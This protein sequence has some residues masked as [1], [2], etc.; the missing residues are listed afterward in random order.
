MRRLCN[1]LLENYPDHVETNTDGSNDVQ[2]FRLPKLPLPQDVWD[3]YLRTIMYYRDNEDVL[4][5]RKPSSP[6]GFWSAVADMYGKRRDEF[7]GGMPDDMRKNFKDLMKG[8][9]N[10]RAIDEEQMGS[11]RSGKDALTTRAV[12]WIQGAAVNPLY[13]N[14]SQQRYAALMGCA[15]LLLGIR[16]TLLLWA[17]LRWEGDCILFSMKRDKES[18]DGAT[19]KLA[20]RSLHSHPSSIPEVDFFLW[21]GLR[22]GLRRITPHIAFYCK[23]TDLSVLCYY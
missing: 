6:N 21:L 20:V 15:A 7:P 11:T 4:R 9:G 10:A 22:K 14:R 17:N 5:M 1:F 16:I 3:E 19:A 8:F 2:Y 23:S 12:M 13:T 18:Q